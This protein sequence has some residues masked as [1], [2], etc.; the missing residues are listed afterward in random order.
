[1]AN[2]RVC[3]TKTG[4]RDWRNSTRAASSSSPPPP[5]K[6][7]FCASPS[8]RPAPLS[9]A[10][11]PPVIQYSSLSPTSRQTGHK[12]VCMIDGA[13]DMMLHPVWFTQHPPRRDKTSRLPI[14]PF[15]LR[16]TSLWCLKAPLLLIHIYIKSKYLIGIVCTVL[17][18]RN[19]RPATVTVLRHS[20]KPAF[21]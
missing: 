2:K 15:C 17:V 21:W 12:T 19:P 7:P 6:S 9:L 3:Q 20:L 1:M 14:E 4:E 5:S 16:F 13:G 8:H 10:L 11:Y 18:N